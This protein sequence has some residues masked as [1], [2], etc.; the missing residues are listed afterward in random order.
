MDNS[1]AR[2][3]WK[4]CDS[5]N[6]D[7][8]GVCRVEHVL[9]VAVSWRTIMPSY[10][11][12]VRDYSRIWMNDIDQR[13]HTRDQDAICFRQRHITCA[14]RKSES[15]LRGRIVVNEYLFES[16]I[17]TLFHLARSHIHCKWIV[18]RSP[19]WISG[20][21]KQPR[22]TFYSLFNRCRAE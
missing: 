12:Q 11:C 1:L 3:A 9:G 10:K 21:R 4:P 18:I 17:R 22:D 6:P 14:L 13:K 5:K 7:L 16:W 2:G 20:A 8:M 15:L 19:S